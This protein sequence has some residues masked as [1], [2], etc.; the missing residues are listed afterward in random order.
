MIDGNGTPLPLN[1][2]TADLP[3]LTD[4]DF[5]CWI[6]ENIDSIIEFIENHKKLNPCRFSD[7]DF[8]EKDEKIFRERLG[9]EWN[10]D[11]DQDY[12][13]TRKHPLLEEQRQISCES[14]QLNTILA[15][16]VKYFI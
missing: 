1:R 11:F 12:E 14:F 9:D 8:S 13:F 6:D 2:F 7:P 3:N 5:Q 4:V 15:D 10:L 16:N